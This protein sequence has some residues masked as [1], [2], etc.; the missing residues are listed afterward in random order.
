MKEPPKNVRGTW[1]FSIGG[2]Q[3]YSDIEKAWSPEGYLTY[4]DAC[5]LAIKEAKRRGVYS[6]YLLP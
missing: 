1:W 6:V 4:A 5:K 2:T 3:G